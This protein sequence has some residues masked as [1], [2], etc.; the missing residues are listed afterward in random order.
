MIGNVLGIPLAILT[1][2]VIKD[3][4]ILETAVD[5]APEPKDVEEIPQEIEMN[6][7]T[8]SSE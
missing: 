6:T 1:V 4:S 3:A 8:V 2:K 7:V 5:L